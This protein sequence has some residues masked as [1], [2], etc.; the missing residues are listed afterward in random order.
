MYKRQDPNRP[1]RIALL[2]YADG[3]KRY[4]LAPNRLS[5]GDRI[6]NGPGA[7]IKPCLLY[8]SRCV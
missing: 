8:T 1:A 5:Q 2:H 6:E 7:D 3:E 4:I